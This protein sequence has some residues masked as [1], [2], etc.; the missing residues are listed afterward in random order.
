MILSYLRHLLAFYNLPRHVIKSIVDPLGSHG[1]RGTSKAIDLTSYAKIPDTVAAKLI[2]LFTDV[3]DNEP[4]VQTTE[5]KNLLISY[6]LVLGLM[7]DDYRADPYDL[8]VELRM[9]IS[10]LKKHYMEIGCK[11]KA[12]KEAD[13]GAVDLKSAQRLYEAVLPVPL[14]FPTLRNAPKR[15]R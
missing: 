15:K 5:K 9:S 11:F 13:R 10:E 12:V 14:Q 8:A 4:R 1:D 2:K 7:I 6:I 3:N